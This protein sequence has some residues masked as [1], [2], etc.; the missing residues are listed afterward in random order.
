[1][2]ISRLRGKAFAEA[3]R[4][5]AV[6]TVL[7]NS[8]IDVCAARGDY[9]GRARD[10]RANAEMSTGLVANIRSYNGVISASTRQKN[11]LG[12]L[13]AWNEINAQSLEPTCAHVRRDARR[14][15]RGERSERGLVD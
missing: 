15:R 10:A 13:W 2:G 1:V 3:N 5:E 7:Y 9:D 6:D 8:F 14:G 12:A 11:F 4:V